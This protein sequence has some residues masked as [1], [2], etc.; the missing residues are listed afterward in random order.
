MTLVPNKPI[1][2]MK[3]VIKAYKDT[4]RRGIIPDVGTVALLLTGRDSAVSEYQRRFDTPLRKLYPSPAGIS[5]A[6][7]A[8]RGF[9]VVPG[10]AQQELSP[11]GWREYDSILT[12]MSGFLEGTLPERHAH[13]VV[14]P[15]VAREL[16][17]LDK[18]VAK[19]YK[20]Y[21]PGK[22]HGEWADRADF[23]NEVTPQDYYDAV[24]ALQK[25]A[26][27]IGMWAEQEKVDL[28]K[29]DLATALAAVED[30]EVDY[31]SGVPQGVVVMEFD[32]GYTI[33]DLTSREQLEAEGDVMGHCVGGYCEQVQHGEVRIYS[34]RDPKGKPHTTIEWR[35]NI[36]SEG[37][38]KGTQALDAA[39]GEAAPWGFDQDVADTVIEPVPLG[40]RD[41]WDRPAD[42]IRSGLTK[43]GQFVQIRG[44]QNEMPA[45]KYRV[46]AQAFINEYFDADPLGLLMVAMPNQTI[47]FK[48]HTIRDIDFTDEWAWEDVPFD[49]ADFRGAHFVKCN[50]GGD[51]WEGVRFEE[52]T[53]QSCSLMEF[54]DC[55]FDKAS[56]NNT[57]LDEGV[58]TGAW[59]TPDGSGIKDCSFEDAL[60]RDSR[61]EGNSFNDCSFVEAHFDRCVL[62]NVDFS[63]CDFTDAVIE[64]S[65]AQNV[66]FDFT[67]MDGLTLRNNAWQLLHI[68]RSNMSGMGYHSASELWRGMGEKRG[69]SNDWP[70]DLLQDEAMN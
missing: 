25:K 26:P 10:G 16:G 5:R 30:F 28:N 18:S 66:S 8:L 38:I 3:H 63:G 53:F 35:P 17:R 61:F 58:A 62:A 33:Q 29:T 44:K 1:G 48:G 49:Q 12:I 46:Y 56:F 52:T 4:P 24:A 67:D 57:V 55:S 42:F 7:Q 22:R 14:I 40:A 60:F 59:W 39:V 31:G 47:Q 37:W 50:V 13:D 45:E 21:G 69:E 34:L 15:W 19:S 27:V 32:D 6:D 20:K 11:Q 36:K 54:F 64:G 65:R 23:Y 68:D 70:E 2:R 9:D 51:G 43:F 41:V